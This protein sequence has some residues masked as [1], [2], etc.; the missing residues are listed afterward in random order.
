M[1]NNTTI[2]SSSLCNIKG[3]LR[4]STE[5]PKSCTTT[6]VISFC[7]YTL[8]FSNVPRPFPNGAMHP[9]YCYCKTKLR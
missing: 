6:P 5:E 3:N 4:K 8:D 9:T 7:I 2:P 1:N